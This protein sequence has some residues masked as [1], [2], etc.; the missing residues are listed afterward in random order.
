ME[1]TQN[2]R[3]TIA[4]DTLASAGQHSG[5][6]DESK[7]VKGEKKEVGRD[8]G[9]ETCT[10]LGKE[11]QHPPGL[12]QEESIAKDRP[13]SDAGISSLGGGMGRDIEDSPGAADA[14]AGTAQASDEE[15][16]VLG[17]QRN[18]REGVDKSEEDKRSAPGAFL[19][20]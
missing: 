6:L 4:K 13:L 14:K 11:D 9:Y 18:S 1:A 16:D 19:D 12:V 8:R 17:E 10:H 2:T 7:D 20:I 3:P 15:E 5:L